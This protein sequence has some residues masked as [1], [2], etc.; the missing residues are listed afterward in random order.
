MVNMEKQTRAILFL[1]GSMFIRGIPAIFKKPRSGRAGAKVTEIK[2]CR[3]D[4]C[5]V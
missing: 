5:L 2:S 3:P 4:L 1:A